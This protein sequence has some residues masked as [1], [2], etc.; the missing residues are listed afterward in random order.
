M[1]PRLAMVQRAVAAILAKIVDD[2]NSGR[3]KPKPRKPT[4]EHARRERDRLRERRN[5]E[6][7]AHVERKKEAQP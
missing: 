2:L 6:L 3:R 7:R 5:A 4:T 1:S